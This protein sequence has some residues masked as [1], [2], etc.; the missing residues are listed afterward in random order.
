M[1]LSELFLT[2]FFLKNLFQPKP[3]K[4]KQHQYWGK[5]KWKNQLVSYVIKLLSLFFFPS[6]AYSVKVECSSYYV[7]QLHQLHQSLS[8]NTPFITA[9]E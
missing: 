7:P 8:K 9:H 1:S 6:A 2:F 4:T 5:I 3:T